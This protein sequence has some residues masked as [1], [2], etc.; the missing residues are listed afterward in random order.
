[1]AGEM[2]SDIIGSCNSFLHLHTI[3]IC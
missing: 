1:V 3:S 2:S